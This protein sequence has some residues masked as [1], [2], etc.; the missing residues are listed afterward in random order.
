MRDLLWRVRTWWAMRWFKRNRI[1][2]RRVAAWAVHH[3][4]NGGSHDSDS[5]LD[6]NADRRIYEAA[7][8][9]PKE[10]VT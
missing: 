8:E 1:R 7:Y 2:L 6:G 4:S 5:I 9:Q 10:R 3:Q